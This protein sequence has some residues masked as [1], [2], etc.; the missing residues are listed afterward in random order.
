LA[1][2]VL[3]E[4]AGG[5]DHDVADDPHAVADALGGKIARGHLRG[6]EQQFG[7]VVDHH[8]I[9]FL[10]HR[11]VERAQPG[12]DMHD[13]DAELG[14]SEPSGERG[15]GVPVDQYRIGLPLD[16]E[17]LE[18]AEHR[19]G[20]P[21]VRARADAERVIGRGYAELLE[22]DVGHSVVVVLAR[23]HEDLLVA[24]AQRLADGRGLHELR[25]RTYDRHD[26]HRV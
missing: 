12:L 6:A 9:D 2:G 16:E 4:E 22:E 23:V 19:S 5:V 24:F 13:R 20:H 3:G 14:G 7:E 15:V 8:P 10:G 1:V 25:P 11:T 17:L 21:S 18:Q 26:P